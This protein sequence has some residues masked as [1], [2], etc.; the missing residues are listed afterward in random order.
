M[1]VTVNNNTDH[2]GTEYLTELERQTAS[3]VGKIHQI[4]RLLKE[5]VDT[6]IWVAMKGTSGKSQFPAFLSDGTKP[7][8]GQNPSTEA[9]ALAT[10]W[11]LK[12]VHRRFHFVSP[13]KLDKLEQARKRLKDHLLPENADVERTIETLN[14]RVFGGLNPLTASHVERVLVAAGERQAHRDIGFLCFFAMLWSLLRRYPEHRSAGARVEPWEPTA[15]VTANCLH[16]ILAIRDI[17]GRR[18]DSLNEI[19]RH[20]E[21]LA[22]QVGPAANEDPSAQWAF[23]VKLDQLSQSLARLATLAIDRDAVVSCEDNVASVSAGL[24]INSDYQQVFRKV[25]EYVRHAIGAIGDQAKHASDEAERLLDHLE[26]ELVK[27]LCQLSNRAKAKEDVREGTK[28]LFARLR[29]EFVEEYLSDAKHQREYLE[30]L[31]DSV[32]KC[33][34]FAMLMHGMLK[35]AGRACRALASKRVGYEELVNTLDSLSVTNREVANEVQEKVKEPASWC[36]SV[37]TQEIAHASAGNMSALDASELIN[38]LSVAVRCQ[39]LKSDQEVKDAVEKALLGAEP[40]GSWKAGRPYYSPDNA[41][42]IWPATSDVIWTLT[43]VIE[44]HP[45]VAVADEA[46]FRYL[47]WLERTQ[48]QVTPLAAGA[49]NELA[50]WPLKGWPSERLQHQRKVHLYTTI[51]TVNA[52]LEIRDLVEYRLWQLCQRRFSAIRVFG[53]LSRLDPVDLGAIHARRLHSQLADLARRARRGAADAEYS[54]ILHGPPGSSKTEVA[55][56]L[57]SEAWKDTNRWGTKD[58]R[59]IRITPA[60]FTRLGEDRVDSEAR[61]IFELLSHVR[62]VTIHFDEIDDLLRRRNRKDDSLV[63]LDLTVPAMLNRLADLRDACPKQEI[64]FLLTTNYVEK[65]EPALIRKGRIDRPVAVVYPD[66]ESRLAIFWRHARTLV[67]SVGKQGDPAFTLLYRKVIERLRGKQF[68]RFIV[69]YREKTRNW[70]WPAI[71]AA[72]KEFF[73]S[74]EFFPRPMTGD[75]SGNREKVKEALKTKPKGVTEALTGLLDRHRDHLVHVSYGCRWSKQD[76][77]EQ[78]I[79][80]Y[81]RYLIAAYANAADKIPVDQRDV[82]GCVRRLIVPENLDTKLEKLWKLDDRSGQAFLLPD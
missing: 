13:D 6:L 45:K 8:Q 81:L 75:S 61:L 73:S 65:I 30:D 57:A 41:L 31:A 68:T 29:L 58:D 10:I 9:L 77:C 46:L 27:P 25:T 62:G 22:A 12:R 74:R 35:K 32:K 19:A 24:T 38:A 16:R 55:K 66:A 47:D 70:P 5:P 20:F 49:G 78:L 76:K 33:L 71:D 14:S 60:D 67:E 21:S 18:A 3:F 37:L 15:Y 2:S 23:N 26:S 79:E 56:A 64:C 1:K 36:R 82:I 63:F 42:G 17:A 40:D 50:E 43:Q 52:L 80:E 34:K 28:E 48:T 72:L 69:S 44:Q 59:Y 51:F 53:G 54:L 7:E 11:R 39:L 4:D